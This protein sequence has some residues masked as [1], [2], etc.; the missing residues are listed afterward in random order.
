M[1]CFCYF[2]QKIVFIL[3]VAHA[4]TFFAQICPKNKNF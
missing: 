4:D 3:D 1:I 2:Y